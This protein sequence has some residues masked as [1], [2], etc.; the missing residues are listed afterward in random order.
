MEY[1][2]RLLKK[3]REEIIPDLHKRFKYKNI[4]QV[5][6]LEKIVV[7]MGVGEAI[8]NAKALDAAMEDLEVITGQHP[9]VTRSKKAISNFK[10]RAG[11]PIGCFVTLRGWRMYEFLDR[12]INIAI[13]RVRDFRGL[14]DKSLDGRGN[15][16]IGLKEQIV[17]PEIDYDKID[18]IRGMNITFVTSAKSDEEAV[19]LLKGFGMPFMK[20]E[21]ESEV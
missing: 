17:F 8:E 6:K 3:Y 4:M 5:P 2:P 16:N 1:F 12:L 21:Q 10:L 18:K 7:N 20:R 9:K 19:E 14:P 11:M 13:P 15:Y